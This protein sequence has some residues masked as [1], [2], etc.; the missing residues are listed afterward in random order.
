M[1]NWDLGRYVKLIFAII[2]GIFAFT[3]KE[4]MMLFVSAFFL[5]QA[6]F[7]VS[8]CGAGGCANYTS[9]EREIFKGQITDY[10][11]NKT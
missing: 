10:K 2:I 7:N 4:Y 1:K 11:K 9:N 5:L 8:C 6:I 3:S